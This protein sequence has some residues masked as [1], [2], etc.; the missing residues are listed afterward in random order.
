ML[1]Q[2]RIG[3]LNEAVRRAL[4]ALSSQVNYE[5]QSGSKDRH[6]AGASKRGHFSQA[7]TGR[8]RLSA[9]ASMTA[10]SVPIQGQ[11]RPLRSLNQEITNA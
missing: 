10:I 5:P 6:S 9:R 11:E 3:L 4:R 1:L 8:T 2:N 7:E